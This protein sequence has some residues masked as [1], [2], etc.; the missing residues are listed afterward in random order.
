MWGETLK[1]PVYAGNLADWRENFVIVLI[2]KASGNIGLVC[3]RLYAEVLV[4]ESGLIAFDCDTYQQVNMKQNNIIKNDLR[5][6][7]QKAGNYF[8]FLGSQNYT[9]P[10]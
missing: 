5:A 8:I 3:K 10:L 1:D 4:K 7:N 9:K 2:D 6:L